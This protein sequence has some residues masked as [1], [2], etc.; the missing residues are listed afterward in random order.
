MLHERQAGDPGD[1]RPDAVAG[2]AVVARREDRSRFWKAIARGCRA[3]T[4][5]SRLGV[6]PAVG[7]RWFREAGGMPPITSGPAVGPLPVVRRARGDRDPA[8]PAARGARDRPPARPVAVDDL[9]G[10]APQRGDPQQRLDYRATT[11]QWHAE[12]RASRPKVAKLAANDALREY[13]QDRLAGTIARP[14]ASRCRARRCGGSVVVTAAARTGAGRSRGARSRSRTGCGSTSPMMSRCG[15]R[16]RRST[17]RSTSKA[18][19]PSS[20]ELVA[21]LR[22]GRALRVPT[23]PHPRARQEVRHPGGHDQRAARRGRRPRRA[24][25]LGRRPDP[26]ARQLRD[27]DAGRAHHP[28]HDAA[29]PAPH[30]R[31]RRPAPGQERAGAR[32]ARRRGR[33]RRHRRLDRDAARAAA[34]LVD[35]GPGRRDGPARP[36]AHRHRP[37]DLLLRPA[38]PLAARHQRE[39]QRAAAPVLPQGHRPRQTQPATTSTPSPLALNSRPRKTLG[40]K[41]PAEALDELLRSVQQ[42]GVATTP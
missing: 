9:A 13:V 19:A 20:R 23:S 31:P 25:P 1:A 7:T 41:T 27:R 35:L 17:R 11:A 36:A 38:Q 4:R 26:R 32:R 37:G 2:P 30:G 39:H 42:G 28:V 22:T 14:T 3:R 33:P 40:W 8:R 5:R 10:A 29:A 12:R 18:A 6:S 15:S 16:T 21:C 24:R 34:P